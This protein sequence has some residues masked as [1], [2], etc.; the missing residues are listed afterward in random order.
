MAD[1]DESRP[2][3][4]IGLCIE[5]V[6]SRVVPHPRGGVGYWRCAKADD[7]PRYAKFPRLPVRECDG[8]RL[9]RDR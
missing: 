7:D 4:D 6:H 5:C 8:F 2:A 1:S 3:T 9:Q